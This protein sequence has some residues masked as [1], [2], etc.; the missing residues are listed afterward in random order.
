MG[1]FGGQAG[2]NWTWT[3]AL[4]TSQ[5]HDL[6]ENNRLKIASSTPVLTYDTNA[7]RGWLVAEL[8]VALQLVR[9]LYFTADPP[10]E[11]PVISVSSGDGKAAL[12]LIQAKWDLV[13][14][15]DADGTSVTLAKR[16]KQFLTAFEQRKDAV[17]ARVEGGG[18]M[19]SWKFRLRSQELLAWDFMDILA[20][21]DFPR[22]RSVRVHEQLWPEAFRNNPK[23]L[24][25]CCDGLGEPIKPAPDLID[26]HLC[27]K[28]QS[29]TER[30]QL[31]GC[32]CA[33]PSS[34][35][36]LRG[37]VWMVSPKPRFPI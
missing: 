29:C 20:F 4:T 5:R 30:P 31:S 16:M 36:L 37:G 1:M 34:K 3:S 17:Q 8:C 32:G 15:K 28:M 24:N 2:V 10:V 13:L 27:G 25:V 9:E 12:D 11:V 33:I 23:I 35:I 19:M 6:L 22:R 26:R 7:R 21:E 18:F 14:E